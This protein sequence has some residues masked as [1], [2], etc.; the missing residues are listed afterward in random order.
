MIKDIDQST[1]DFLEKLKEAK[2]S[3][4][5]DSKKGGSLKNLFK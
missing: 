2:P 3:T 4:R 1:S 5:R